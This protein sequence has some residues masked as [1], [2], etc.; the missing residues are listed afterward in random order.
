MY[1]TYDKR[2]HVDKTFTENELINSGSSD[3]QPPP[4][5]PQHERI[6]LA[7]IKPFQRQRGLQF[8]L[9]FGPTEA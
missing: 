3:R 8:T 5:P 6:K 9:L 7:E 1:V 2:M 4:P